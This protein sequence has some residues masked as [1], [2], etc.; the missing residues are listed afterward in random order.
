MDTNEN[1]GM[2]WCGFH[3]ESGQRW[4]DAH[5]SHI[6]HYDPGEVN[7]GPDGTMRLGVAL[8]PRT[9]E[10]RTYHWGVGLVHSVESIKYGELWVRFRLP[11]GAGLWPAI[12]MYDIDQWPPEID[13][14]EAWSGRQQFPLRRGPNYRRNLLLDYVYPGV[15]MRDRRLS[16][17]GGVRLG[18]HGVWP[19]VIDKCGINTVAMYWSPTKLQIRY[20]GRQVMLVDDEPTLAELNA[21]S[22]MQ[23]ILNN[24]VSSEFTYDD[25][26]ALR[27]HDFTI[28][29]LQHKPL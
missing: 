5:P 7:I 21:S 11:L 18:G 26:V 8:K 25:Y 20:N 28:Y 23:I 15:V 3:W 16:R 6:C 29:E 14:L 27:R 13:L 4:G 1:C 10:G 12:W 19:S 17:S 2:E 22:G 9:I 24:Y